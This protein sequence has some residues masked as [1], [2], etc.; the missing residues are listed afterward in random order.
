MKAS[1]IAAHG[2]RRSGAVLR[3][4][5]RRVV[6]VDHGSGQP[7]AAIDTAG[8]EPSAGDQAAFLNMPGRAVGW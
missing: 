7:D 5:L 3:Q 8:P 1:L 6:D 4:L 2:G